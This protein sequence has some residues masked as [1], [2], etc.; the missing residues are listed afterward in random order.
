MLDKLNPGGTILLEIPMYFCNDLSHLYVPSKKGL[1]KMLDNLSLDY[2]Y[3]E[4]APACNILIGDRYKDTSAEKVFYTY[5]SP[6][7]GS[8]RE[9]LD[10]LKLYYEGAPSAQKGLFDEAYSR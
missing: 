3:L 4:S 1:E 5:E 2:L 10:W 6:D 9:V 8:R 7:F